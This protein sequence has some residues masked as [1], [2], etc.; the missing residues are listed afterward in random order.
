MFTRELKFNLKSFILWTSCLIVLC[1]L[2]FMLYKSII[3]GDSIEKINEA[4]SAFPPDVLKMFN[5]DI[6]NID[7]AYGWLKTE[8]IVF[9]MIISGMFSA[10]LGI[11]LLLKE[12]DEKTVEYMMSL[13]ITPKSVM[14]KKFVV[15][16]I[17]IT[18]MIIILTIFNL[19]ALSLTG[20]FKVG[21][22]ILM[23][24]TPLM[25]S[26]VIYSLCMFIS[27]FTHKTKKVFSLS[28]GIVFV[29]YFLYAV[30][31]MNEKVEFLKYFS[32][33]TLADTRNIIT[34]LTVNP[35]CIIVFVILFALLSLGTYYRYTTKEYL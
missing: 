3:S 2:V 35:I 10:V 15:G 12:E 26:F 9:I 5:L 13:P 7:S 18:A 14:I 22:F 20:E 21:E 1:L 16:I 28:L 24:V 6:S 27:T 17:Y 30:S 33:F 32:V 8:G 11:N 29:S 25:P 4:M 34:N 19:V 23:S 31:Q